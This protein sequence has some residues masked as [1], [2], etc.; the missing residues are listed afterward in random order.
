[1]D[2]LFE[3]WTWFGYRVWRDF[4]LSTINVGRLCKTN[5]LSCSLPHA[6]KA[7][8]GW[9]AVW[10]IQVNQGIMGSDTFCSLPEAARGR[11]R[12]N[13]E[14]FYMGECHRVRDFELQD[15]KSL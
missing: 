11:G 1:M 4:A 13:G 9:C 5:L 14:G 8:V 3:Y 15:P 2:V 6:T 12:G 10:L 7:L